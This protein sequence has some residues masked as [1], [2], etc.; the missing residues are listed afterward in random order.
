MRERAQA[1]REAQDILAR[2][3]P[4]IPAW[5]VTR[6]VLI[7]DTISTRSGALGIRTEG[8]DW[9]LEELVR[10]GNQ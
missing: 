4:S 7:N 8:W 2:A 5:Y 10:D 1:A 3:M 6:S 9:Q